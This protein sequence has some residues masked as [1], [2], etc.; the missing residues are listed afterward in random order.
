LDLFSGVNNRKLK[1]F[2]GLFAVL[3]CLYPVCCIAQGADLSKKDSISV[4]KT[5]R[6]QA[7]DTMRIDSLAKTKEKFSPNPTKAV[8]FSAIFPGLGQIYNR[9]YWKLPLVY[10]GFIGCLYAITWNGNQ[11]NGYRKA[12]LDFISD[13]EHTTSWKDYLYGSY[14]R[15]D[16]ADWTDAD[17]NGFSDAL[18]RTRDFHRRNRDLSYIVTVGVYAICMIDAYVDAQ[19]FDFDISPDLSM[20]IE[21]MLFDRTFANSRSFGM[22]LSFAF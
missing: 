16:F 20:R 13:P 7:T 19:L 10:G 4:S 22:Q 17:K 5:I 8:L 3:F 14:R 1:R 9:K 21:P 12:Y 18:K 6:I 15:K 11:Y 2:I